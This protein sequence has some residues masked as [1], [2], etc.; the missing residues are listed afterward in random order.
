MYYPVMQFCLL[1]L[2]WHLHVSSV[3]QKCSFFSVIYSTIRCT[4][5]CD[6]Q[7]HLAASVVPSSLASSVVLPSTAVPL[8]ASLSSSTSSVS[9]SVASSVCKA[10]SHLKYHFNKQC[11]IC[12]T[13]N[14]T[15]WFDAWEQS[16]LN[17]RRSLWIHCTLVITSM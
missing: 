13:V 8:A 2:F 14:C 10:F 11:A 12:S 4:M 9:V 7:Y 3:C 17:K 15:K 5:H 16:F 6:M 1:L